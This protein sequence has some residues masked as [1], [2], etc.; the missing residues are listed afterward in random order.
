M[1][2]KAF[3]IFM[4][5]VNLFLCAEATLK[6]IKTPVTVKKRDL[7]GLLENIFDQRNNFLKLVDCSD[8]ALQ[9]KASGEIFMTG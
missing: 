7:L 2:K 9:R 8:S 6:L 1:V 4:I 3:L 5:D